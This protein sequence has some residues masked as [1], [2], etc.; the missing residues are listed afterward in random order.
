MTEAKIKLALEA[1]T[2][3]GWLYAQPES[4]KMTPR[5]SQRGLLWV[6][7]AHPRG[8]WVPDLNDDATEGILWKLS[9]ATNVAWTGDG[10]LHSVVSHKEWR[11][12]CRG[13]I[14]DDYTDHCTDVYGDT[15]A[16]VACQV[17][18]VKGCWFGGAK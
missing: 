5:R 13:G 11:P 7:S 9:G 3:P 6:R 8:P 10:R 16:E 2:L 15:M 1:I 18:K 4:N 17:A 12:G 14:V